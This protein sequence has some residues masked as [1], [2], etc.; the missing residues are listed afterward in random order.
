MQSLRTVILT[1]L[2]AWRFPS[3]VPISNTFAY[4]FIYFMPDYSFQRR[5]SLDDFLF[6]V[7]V[8]PVCPLMPEAFFP[9]NIAII[10]PKIGSYV[11]RLINA[12]LKDFFPRS[13]S[14]KMEFWQYRR[15]FYSQALMG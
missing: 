5:A 1:F 2:I 4:I 10:W 13:L 14:I 6:N 9:S 8:P 3:N 11:Y 7:S 15:H 12:A